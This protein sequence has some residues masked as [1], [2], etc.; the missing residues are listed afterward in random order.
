MILPSHI[1]TQQ[2]QQQQQQQQ[3]EK[4]KRDYIISFLFSRSLI[5][6]NKAPPGKFKLEIGLF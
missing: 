2:Q 3:K 5:K 4:K 1:H 6:F